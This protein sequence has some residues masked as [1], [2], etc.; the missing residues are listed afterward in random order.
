MQFPTPSSAEVTHQAVLHGP[1]P[2]SFFE[3][4]REILDSTGSGH[5][6]QY[7]FLHPKAGGPTQKGL[8][9]GQEALEAGALCPGS[10]VCVT[11]A[12]LHSPARWSG[13]SWQRE[14]GHPDP[15]RHGGSVSLLSCVFTWL[16]RREE[17]PF[18]SPLRLAPGAEG[19]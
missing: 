4:T 3:K 8:G 5:P 13:L 6:V 17:T 12:A 1:K 2:Q 11:Q 19:S 9:S 14:G 15:R 18:P 7:P 10:V 16:T